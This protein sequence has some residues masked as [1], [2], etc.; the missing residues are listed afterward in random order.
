M[1]S[2]DSPFVGKLPQQ[3]QNINIQAQLNMGIRYLQAQTHH[4]IEDSR[5]LELCHTSC[6]LENAGTLESFLVTLKTWLDANPND[7]VTLLLTNGDSVDIIEFADA[8][9]K[10]GITS[11]AFV[12]SSSPQPLSINKWPTIGDLIS[13]GKRLVVFLGKFSQVCCA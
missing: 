9:S 4:S 8:F 12:P 6:F 7:V 11:Y 13:S 1:G 3:N 10:S 5:V 2:H